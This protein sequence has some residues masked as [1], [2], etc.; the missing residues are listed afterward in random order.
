MVS[1]V[2]GQGK[3]DECAEK[4]RKDEDKKRSK[5]LN[6]TVIEVEFGLEKVFYAYHVTFLIWRLWEEKVGTSCTVL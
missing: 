5:G 3:E 4:R 1:P 2:H 6:A